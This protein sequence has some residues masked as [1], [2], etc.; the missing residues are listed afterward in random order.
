[1]LVEVP[2]PVWK[3]STTNWSSNRPSATSPAACEMAS[4]RVPSSRSRSLFTSAAAPFISPI[5][6]MNDLG[7]RRPLMGKLRSARVVW[8]P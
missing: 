1:M 2:D 6:L 4:A 3:M 5:A 8:A 7:K